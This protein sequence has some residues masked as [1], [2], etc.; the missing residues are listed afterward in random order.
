[1]GK[2]ILIVEDDPAS[3]KLTR[4]LLSVAGYNTLQ[5][6][7]GEQGIELAKANKPDLILMD[8]M[9]PKIDGYGACFALKSDET[10]KRIPIIMLTAIGFDLNKTLAERLGANGYITKPIDTNGLLNSVK[11]YVGTP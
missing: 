10:T 2:T 3:Q 1:M 11:S 5:A 8:I 4:D 7:D 6:T 9:M